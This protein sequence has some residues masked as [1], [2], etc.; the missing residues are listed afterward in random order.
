MRPDGVVVPPPLLD[1]NSRL[2]GAVED[3]PVEQLVTQLAVEALVVAVLPGTAG[4]DEQGLGP[5]L[6]EPGAHLAR[7]HLRPVVRADML[8]DTVDQHGVGKHLDDAGP[9]EPASDLDRQAL[10]GELDLPDFLVQLL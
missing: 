3:L 1:D 2:F 5:D 7:G 4:L 9:A 8:G 6:F 10:A